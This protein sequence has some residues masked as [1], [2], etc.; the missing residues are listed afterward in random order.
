MALLV[1]YGLGRWEAG[2]NRGGMDPRRVG[3]VKVGEKGGSSSSSNRQSSTST[4]TG[5]GAKT[6]PKAP[7]P[8]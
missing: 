2:S 4:N 7:K 6:P 8:P 3:C 1:L 5:S